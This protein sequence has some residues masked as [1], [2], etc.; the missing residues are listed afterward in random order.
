MTRYGNGFDVFRQ[1][2]APGAIIA[3]WTAGS[4]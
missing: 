1:H 2:Q 4:G 3:G